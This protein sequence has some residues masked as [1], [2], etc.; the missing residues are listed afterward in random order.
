[1]SEEP[2]NIVTIFTEMKNHEVYLALNFF[3]ATG[4]DE[5][6]LQ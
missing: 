4:Q 2:V 6:R 1:M 5:H 3:R